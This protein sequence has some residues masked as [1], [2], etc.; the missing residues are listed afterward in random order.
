VRWGGEKGGSGEEGEDH[1]VC[2]V[3]LVDALRNSALE[4]TCIIVRRHVLYD[5]DTGVEHG[6]GVECQ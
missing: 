2:W 5:T 3:A 6:T 4:M 1:D